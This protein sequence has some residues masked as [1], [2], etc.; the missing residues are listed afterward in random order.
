M[1]ILSS[2]FVVASR[3]TPVREKKQIITTLSFPALT[4]LQ[5]IPDL[6][7]RCSTLSFPLGARSSI[8][9]PTKQV[10]PLLSTFC[11]AS[12]NLAPQPLPPFVNSSWDLVH[13]VPAWNTSPTSFHPHH[14]RPAPL[15]LLPRLASPL[16]RLS[17][18][19]SLRPLSLRLLAALLLSGYS[20]LLLGPAAVMTQIQTVLTPK[21]SRG[22]Y[23]LSY[24]P[25]A[26]F[27]ADN[28]SAP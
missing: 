5:H 11:Y 22:D 27:P 6:Q 13:R 15:P 18:E 2:A 12:S 28:P 9:C 16:S 17:Q 7:Q 1:C 3:R 26:N 23:P 19:T 25:A 20:R 8:S 14:L 21:L 24:A 10:S 4:T